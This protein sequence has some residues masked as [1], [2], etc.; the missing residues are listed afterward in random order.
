[1]REREDQKRTEEAF[2]RLKKA[3]RP[4]I[5][6]DI[7][8]I[9]ILAEVVDP[10]TGRTNIYFLL[11][12]VL[13]ERGRKVFEKL[14]EELDYDASAGYQE[15]EGSRVIDHYHYEKP[16]TYYPTKYENVILVEKKRFEKFG[17]EEKP[18][19]TTWS[20]RHLNPKK[21]AL[22]EVGER[23]RRFISRASRLPWP[24]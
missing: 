4:V 16:P 7:K 5:G 12:D 13:G 1:M 19:R 8:E 20:I 15:E 11:P 9:E 24:N 21:T 10:M 23:A 3:I 14:K 6:G 18:E 22:Q 2:E 17:D